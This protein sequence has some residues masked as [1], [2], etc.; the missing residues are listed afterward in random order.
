MF[1]SLKKSFDEGEI[2]ERLYCLDDK[3]NANTAPSNIEEWSKQFEIFDKKLF[4][5]FKKLFDQIDNLEDTVTIL[6][7]VNQVLSS[8][9]E[10]YFP[11]MKFFNLSE[12][13]Y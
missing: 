6:T 2:F 12:K 3:E 5:F 8:E 1:I 13:T 11:H 4:R 9:N 7:N 10:V